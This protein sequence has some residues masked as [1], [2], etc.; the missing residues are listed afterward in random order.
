MTQISDLHI[1]CILESWLSK[2]DNNDSLYIP[3]FS[4]Y[5]GD[6]GYSYKNHQHT[7]EVSK[8]CNNTGRV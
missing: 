1:I 6:R 5:R 2:Y 4:I 7:N 8:K 3:G